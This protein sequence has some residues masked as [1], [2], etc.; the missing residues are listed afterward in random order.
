MPALPLSQ[1]LQLAIQHHQAGRLQEAEAA[2]RL[3]LT[4]TP[5]NPVALHLLGVVSHETGRH[6]A[7][8][9]LLKKAVELNPSAAE[10]HEDLGDAYAALRWEGNTSPKRDFAQP[11]WEGADLSGRTL[12][13]EAEQGF[14]DMIQFVRY[15]PLAAKRGG[16]VVLECPRGLKS[17]FQSVEGVAHVVALVESWRRKLAADGQGVRVGLAWAGNPRGFQNRLRSL[18][19]SQ[20]APLAE[21]KDVLFSSLQKN[22]A[23]EQ[24]RNPPAGMRVADRM[25]EVADFADTAALVMNLD[26]IISVDTSAAHL[27]GALGKRVWVLLPFAPD[28]RWGLERRDCAWYPTMALYRQ[29][30]RG[31]WA[32]VIERVGKDLADLPA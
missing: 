13:L 9:D 1:T 30:A 4:E 14:G 25:R 27:A 26:L 22:E 18:S 16:R 12:L 32:S 29:A 20:L 24:V 6:Q 11:R 23:A 19:L 21:A 3:A 8:V 17:L 15:A 28:W 5:L 2:C 7:A 31:E 10:I